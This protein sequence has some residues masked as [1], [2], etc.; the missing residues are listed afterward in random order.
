MATPAW[1]V[2]FARQAEKQLER[3]TPELRNRILDRLDGLLTDPPG[4]DILKL[5]GSRDEYRLRVGDWRVIFAR[6]TDE[7]TVEIK[8]VHP[9]GRAYRT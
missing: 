5:H 1:R 8:A 6:N 7:R 9:R 4:G 2:V 3:L